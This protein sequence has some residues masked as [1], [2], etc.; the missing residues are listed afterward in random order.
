MGRLFSANCLKKNFVKTGQ[1]CSFT[2]RKFSLLS[3]SHFQNLKLLLFLPLFFLPLSQ[4][5]GLGLRRDRCSVK[6]KWKLPRHSQ[7]KPDQTIF[8]VRIL[9]CTWTLSEC[10]FRHPHIFLLI[11]VVLARS[12]VQIGI[13]PVGRHVSLH[14]T[15]ILFNYHHRSVIIWTLGT[16]KNEAESSWFQLRW[17]PGSAWANGRI[18]WDERQMCYL[19]WLLRRLLGCFLYLSNDIFHFFRNVFLSFKFFFKVL[20]VFSLHFTITDWNRANNFSRID[21]LKKS[22]DVSDVCA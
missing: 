10:G 8:Y 3:V 4:T 2:V 22:H 21:I 17:T 15:T 6:S 20:Q 12:M 18:C 14:K 11:P 5:L 16:A 7:K 13:P 19:H 1:H 9:S